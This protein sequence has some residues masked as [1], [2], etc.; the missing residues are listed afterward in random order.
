MIGSKGELTQLKLR[1]T[2]TRIF[3]HI[4]SAPQTLCERDNSIEI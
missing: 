3:P 2:I 4:D 1:E